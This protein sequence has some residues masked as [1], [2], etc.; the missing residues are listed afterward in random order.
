MIDPYE[1]H[2]DTPEFILD[3]KKCCFLSDC[4]S[5]YFLKHITRFALWCVGSKRTYKVCCKDHDFGCRYGWKYGMTFK[6]VNEDL[7]EC[8]KGSGHPIIG[9]FLHNG[10]DIFSWNSFRGNWSDER[11]AKKSSKEEV[12]L[13]KLGFYKTKGQPND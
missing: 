4:W 13:L 12:K 6:L 1:K 7:G 8:A 2:Y 9:W 11:L 5:S 3:W 10:T